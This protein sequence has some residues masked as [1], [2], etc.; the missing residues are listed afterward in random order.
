VSQDPAPLKKCCCSKSENYRRRQLVKD[1]SSEENKNLLPVNK[2]SAQQLTFAFSK[3]PY[4]L[5]VM[6]KNHTV[7]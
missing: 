4:H 7:Y 5:S 6:M 2:P 3:L 1:I